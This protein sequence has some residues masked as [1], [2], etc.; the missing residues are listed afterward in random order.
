M[1]D[2]SKPLAII[3]LCAGPEIAALPMIGLT[4]TTG[5]WVCS[6]A[7]RIPG[8]DKIGPML[9]IG[10]LGQMTI[11]SALRIISSTPGA[12]F[13]NSA[14]T[15][16][17]EFTSRAQRSLTKNSWNEISPCGRLHAGLDTL[18]GHREDFRLNPKLA[19]D[20]IGHF[21]QCQTFVEQLGPGD[22]RREILIAKIEPRVVAEIGA[23][24][25]AR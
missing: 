17:T 15:K 10:L 14:P 4:P 5:A 9:V 25:P 8:T 19:A 24:A 13:A 6:R 2:A 18:V 1:A 20:A 11:A 22:M 7:L 12:G 21:G 23:A 3:S 16:R